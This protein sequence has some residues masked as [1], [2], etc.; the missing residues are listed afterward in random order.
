MLHLEQLDC[1]KHSQPIFSKL[2]Y[3]AIQS[4][5]RLSALFAAHAADVII[6]AVAGGSRWPVRTTSEI[7]QAAHLGMLL[8][9]WQALLQA[10][11]QLS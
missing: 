9:E 6:E 3:N 11:T 2:V 4:S 1:C 7:K 8:L 5:T 10:E